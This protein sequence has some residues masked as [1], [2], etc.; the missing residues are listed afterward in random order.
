[1][2]AKVE[3]KFSRA[4]LLQLLAKPFVARGGNIHALLHRNRIP[5]EVLSEPNHLVEAATL[6]AVFEDMA[7]T[8][9]DA[10]FCGGIARDIAL[11]GVPTLL[12]SAASK[13]LGDFLVSAIV[14]TGRQ[15]DNV[16]YS[17]NVTQRAAVFSIKRT[18]TIDRPTPQADAVGVAFYATVFRSGL[19]SVFDARQFIVS[20]PSI[21]GVPPDLL[22][23]QALVRSPKTALSIT[24]P[25]RWLTAAFSL[26]WSANNDKGDRPDQPRSDEMTLAFVRATI[27]L[28]IAD[29]EFD[30][31]KLADA[32]K[33]SRRSIQRILA[34]HGTSFRALQD[35]V[36]REVATALVTHSKTPL[37]DVA[38]QV[39]FSNETSFTRSY[40]RW[41][42][43]PP[44]SHRRRA[45]RNSLDPVAQARQT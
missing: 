27:R 4:I 44:A 25:P 8:L 9:G 20:A 39:G 36:R 38:R 40:S 6:Y 16:D 5:I 28:N 45:S 33:T 22:P 7:T 13:T 31:T 1:M 34:A 24:F 26:N 35:D 32:C 42:G 23:A 43:E 19:G 37:K 15:F 17:L 2:K 11:K 41:I 12:E 10:Y 29:K 3:P 14:E 21:E 30:L 18:R